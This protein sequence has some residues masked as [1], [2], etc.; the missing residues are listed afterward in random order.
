MTPQEMIKKF[1]YPI[2]AV[3]ADLEDANSSPQTGREAVYFAAYQLMRTV[4]LTLVGQ[5]LTYDLPAEASVKAQQSLN[6]AIGGLRSPFFSSW[7]TLLN[8]LDKHRLTLKLDF[9]PEFHDAMEAVKKSKVSVPK[10]YGLNQGTRCEE[11]NWFEALL[12]L[13]NGSAHSGISTDDACLDAVEYFKPILDNT[14]DAFGFLCDYELLALRSDADDDPALVQLLRGEELDDPQQTELDGNLYLAFQRSPVVMC[15]VENGVERIQELFPLFHGHIEGEP[16]RCYDGHYLRDDPKMRRRTIYY[17]GNN[18]RLPLDDEEAIGKVLSPA[19][20]GA[21]DRLREMLQNR[22]IDWRLTRDEVA[23]WTL[24]DTVNDYAE[25]TLEDIIGIKY[26][27]PCYLDRPSLSKPLWGMATA[28]QPLSRAFLLTGRAGSGKTALLCDL[29]ARLLGKKEDD[30]AESD[31]LVFFVRGDG[32]ISGL[33]GGNILL[34]NLLHKIGMNS[35]EFPTFA[36][37]FNHLTEKAKND[38]VENRRFVIVLDAIN[39]APQPAQLFREALE[40]VKAAR[41]HSWLRIVLSAREEFLAV[42][43]GRRGELE[44]SPFYDMQGLFVQPPDNPERQRRPED[45]PAWEVPV[46]RA[47]EAVIVYRNYQQAHSAASAIPACKTPWEA[48]PPA[49]RQDVLRVPLHLDLWMRAFNDKQAPAVSSEAD[50]FKDYLNDLRGRFGLFW[51]SMTV[52]LAHMVNHGRIELNDVDANE[53]ADG[54]RERHGYDAEQLRLRFTPLEVAVA[55][56]V[57]QKRTTA[58]GGG[59]RIPYQRLREVLLYEYL[60][61]CDPG[62]Q[63]E[64]LKQWVAI[65]YMPEMVGALA[66]IAGDL[67]ESDR[68]DELKMF[69]ER[70]D[71]NKPPYLDSLTKAIS[72]RILSKENGNSFTRRLKVLLEALDGD[73]AWLMSLVLTFDVR[74]QLEGLPVTEGLRTM[75]ESAL[76]WMEGLPSRYS[77]DLPWLSVVFGSYD[78]LGDVYRS[79]GAG[80]RAR[81]YYKKALEISERL[82]AAEP[83]RADYAR[84]VS[85][86]YERLGNVYRVLGASDQALEYYQKTLEISERLYAAEPNCAN[87]A[88][89][90]SVSYERLGDACRDIGAGGQA[91]EYYQKDLE[92]S[93]R[94]YAAE[95]GRADYARGISVSYIKVGDVYYDIGAGER[96]LEYYQ[97]ALEISE[98]LYYAEPNHTDYARDVSVLYERLGTVYRNIGAG[99]QALKYYQKNLEISELLYAAEPN[100]VDYAKDVSVSYERLGDMCQDSGAGEQALGYY[101]KSLE[102]SERLYAAEPNRA[103]YARDVSASYNSLGDVYRALGIGDRALEYYQK[104]LEISE[105][106][107]VAEPGRTDY[108][109]DVSISYDAIARATGGLDTEEGRGWFR[110]VREVLRQL[111]Q[112]D[113]MPDKQSSDYLGWLEESLD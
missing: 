94:L 104:T 80:G 41:E 19:V 63:P 33:A 70:E 42:W 76:P 108:A 67:W 79:L 64:S 71:T 105:R 13:R 112:K 50:L 66:R 49:T 62:L 36:E 57:I 16:L 73:P 32:L 74:D 88:R 37:F 26:L 11:L 47:E 92:I 48:I 81:E 27:P 58:E 84:N 59:Y 99:D 111:Q 8:T 113:R 87:Y 101:Q 106:L 24:R 2:A 3:Y 30:R 102:I 68:S 17:L 43:H 90:V 77:D 46:F 40:M 61:E 97:K 28:E 109:R 85:V 65:P 86:S 56:G 39:E 60:R 7:I 52:I 51:E 6:R 31:H 54:W 10:A 110:K 35:N 38:T 93:E 53:I 22:A 12:G 15:R 25:R 96:A 69:L 55:A 29:V 9:M 83:N 44:S 1:P 4:G 107:Y 21:A 100:R 103:D 5:Y 18:E 82:Y 20:S 78:N 75:W 91:L 45:P 98:L 72:E 89:D 34:A 95:P 14:L 23:P